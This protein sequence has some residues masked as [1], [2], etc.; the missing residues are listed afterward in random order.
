MG[1]R[2]DSEALGKSVS[3]AAVERWGPVCSVG[4]HNP[5]P[6]R[7]SCFISLEGL[8]AFQEPGPDEDSTELR[9]FPIGLSSNRSH[10]S[11]FC[12]SIFFPAE[13]ATAQNRR[14]PGPGKAWLG[15]IVQIWDPVRGNLPESFLLG[16]VVVK[17]SADCLHQR[18]GAGDS[19]SLESSPMTWSRTLGAKSQE[20]AT[21]S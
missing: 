16:Q 14:L 20:H 1:T 9:A 12:L 10:L 8:P 11:L 21:G 3:G 17:W 7:G 5:P 19:G 6:S 13:D 15:G 18:K 4:C 2:G